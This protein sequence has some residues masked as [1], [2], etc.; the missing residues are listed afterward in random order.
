MKKLYEGKVQAVEK[1]KAIQNTENKQRLA[2]SIQKL[3]LTDLLVP[4]K[5]IHR[6]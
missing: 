5:E 3:T 6:A 1:P 2:F 4:G